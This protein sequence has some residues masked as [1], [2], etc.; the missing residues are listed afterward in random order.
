MKRKISVGLFA[1]LIWQWSAISFALHDA[2]TKYPIVLIHGFFGFGDGMSWL[3]RYF[4]DIPDL[5]R[6]HGATVY[7][8]SVSQANTIESRGEELYEQ[9]LGWGHGKYNLIGHSHG[10]LDARYV[11]EAHPEIVSSVTTIGSPHRGSRVADYLYDT[12]SRHRSAR[13]LL[14][15]LGEFIGNTIGILSGSFHHLDVMESLR[16]LTTE[17]IEEFNVTH[18]VGIGEDYCQEG[19]HDY[20]GRKLYSWGSADHN[21]HLGGH[22][23]SPLFRLTS[24]VFWDDEDNDGLVTVCSMK[25]GK[26]LGAEMEGHHLVPVGG[27][28]GHILPTQR[29]QAYDM[30]FAHAKRLRADGL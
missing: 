11:L 30:F 5:L 14:L 23:L 18:T 25:F 7:I 3:T 13:L 21:F 15:S 2:E 19:S 10:G 28:L 27:V 22:F 20:R 8:A 26:W 29:Q 16:G 6:S 17:G 1:L 4:G 12:I 24:S 9:L